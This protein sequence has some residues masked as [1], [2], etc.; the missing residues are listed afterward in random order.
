MVGGLVGKKLGR[1]EGSCDAVGLW[2]AVG[3]SLGN[4]LGLADK[5]SSS[6]QSKSTPSIVGQHN[7]SSFK[8]AHP[9]LS[10]HE[11]ISIDGD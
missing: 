10:L 6:Q 9:G 8:T 3:L 5:P 2:D 11:D 1:L 4:V 7:P